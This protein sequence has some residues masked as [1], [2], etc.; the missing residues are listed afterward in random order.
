MRSIRVFSGV[1]TLGDASARRTDLHFDGI[2]AGLESQRQEKERRKGET[3]GSP[4]S[5]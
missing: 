5:A 2:V 4:A 1:T 3:Y